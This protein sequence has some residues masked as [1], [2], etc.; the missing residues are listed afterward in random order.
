MNVSHVVS[1]GVGFCAGAVALV[2]GVPAETPAMS[3][4][5]PA[6]AASASA[7]SARPAPAGGPTAQ[8]A[9]SE[10]FSYEPLDPTGELIEPIPTDVEEYFEDYLEVDYNPHSIELGR[11]LFHDPRLSSDDTVSCASC[12]DLRYAGVD[13]AV[14]ATGVRG[15]VGPI[16]TP[17]VFNSAFNV[18]QFWD[19]RAEDLEAQ[20]DGPPN[21]PGEMA[22]NWAEISSKLSRDGAMMELL[23]AAYPDA[24][25]SEGIEPRF[26]LE[27]IAD[28]ERTLITPNAPFDRYLMGEEDAIDRSAKE[29]YQI[30][31]DIGCIE[32]HNGMAVGGKSFQRLGRKRPYFGSHTAA[33][34]L[35][36]FNVTGAEEDRNAFKVGS[37]RNVALTAPYFH[38][39]SQK[40]L[41]DAIRAMAEHQLDLEL[42]GAQVER[43]EAF[44]QTLTGEWCGLPLDQVQ[45]T[46]AGRAPTPR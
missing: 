32:C 34:D 4:V 37:L 24:D 26:W 38:D 36:R 9:E 41:P 35:G 27:A 25:F 29:G 46:G 39:G 28:F 6:P 3:S 22:S 23:A 40:T 14:T 13:R 45:N 33:V 7:A 17:T 8:A 1:F 42:S 15:Q 5:P 20:A 31:K 12:H 21:A 18:R 30:F 19:G 2:A 16:N 43:I 10:T 44:L 11:R